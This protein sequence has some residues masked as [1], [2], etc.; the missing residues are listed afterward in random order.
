MAKRKEAKIRFFPLFLALSML[1]LVSSGIAWLGCPLYALLVVGGLDFLD[2]LI[3]FSKYPEEKKN[4]KKHL[5]DLWVD[6]A[7]FIIITS[8]VVRYTYPQW[9]ALLIGLLALR[10]IGSAT[11]TL[12]KTYW[13]FV[14]TPNI[15]SVLGMALLYELAYGKLLPLGDINFLVP[16]FVAMGVAELWWHN[17]FYQH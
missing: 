3:M 6:I 2:G 10:I 5:I 17:S 8:Y 15:G 1:R 12:Y 14:F 4:E 13:V 11:R 7:C 9:Q 16:L